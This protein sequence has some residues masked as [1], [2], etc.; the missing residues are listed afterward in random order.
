MQAKGTRG[1]MEA[2]SMIAVRD[3]LAPR[4]GWA[5]RFGVVERSAVPTNLGNTGV[6]EG[7]QWTS[8]VGSNKGLGDW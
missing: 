6:G 2:P 3:Q 1:N 8:N 7:P 4:E 5:G